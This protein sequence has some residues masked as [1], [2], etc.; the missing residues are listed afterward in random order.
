MANAL[1][2][3]A[4]V[5]ESGA[6]GKQAPAAFRDLESAGA[7][8]AAGGEVIVEVTFSSLNYK[9]GLAVTGKGKVLKQLPIVPG[10]DLVG[11]V[12]EIGGG[13]GNASG[14]RV[15]DEVIV[16]GW[17]I[18]ESTSGGYATLARVKSD[19]CV[20]LPGGL[21]ARR[22]MGIGTAGF[23]AMLCVLAL[24]DH[25]VTPGEGNDIVVTGAAGGVGS[26]AVAVL[27]KLGHRVIAST[28]R[29]EQEGDYL[30]DLGAAELLARDALAK[31][32]GKPL[33]SEHWAGG[34]DSVGGET[35][36]SVLRQTRQHGSVAACGLAGGANLPTTVMPFILRG[37]NLL[38]INSNTC[39]RAR[40][41]QAWSR[42]AADLD[43]DKLEQ[44]TE[45]I[46]L[47]DVP[48]YAEE[49]LAGRVRGR[50]VVDVKD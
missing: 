5:V 13:D 16:T 24:E 2:H 35:L 45:T 12:A 44:M 10:I 39:P 32:S 14:L 29:V 48:R 31:P 42:L 27:A 1:K 17:G 22:A 4:L 43:L 38:G 30:R 21:D 33:D 36:A 49:I 25:G 37:V 41:E 47:R 19:W 26:V 34:V 20:K 46:A 3:R 6:D 18:G 7:L 11:R 8:P 23:T 40:R 15:G 28:G 50:V 9:D